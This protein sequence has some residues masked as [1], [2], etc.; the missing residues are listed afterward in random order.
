MLLVSDKRAECAASA[1]TTATRYP[2]LTIK[3]SDTYY[4]QTRSYA[5]WSYKK[6]REYWK[7]G[8]TYSSQ[9]FENWNLQSFVDLVNLC[10]GSTH[11]GGNAMDL[12]QYDPGCTHPQFSFSKMWGKV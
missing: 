6:W 11:I 8:K 3:Q 12:S 9:Q 4:P 5:K 2:A 10:V 7:F 1:S